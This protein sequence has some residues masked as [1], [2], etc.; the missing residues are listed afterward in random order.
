[1]K[2]KIRFPTI[3]LGSEPDQP[4]IEELTEFIRS[5]KSYEGDLITFKHLRSL[6]AQQDASITSPCTGG[7]FCLPRIQEAFP[8]PSEKL[9][10]DA[11]NLIADATMITQLAGS[12]YAALPAP[13]QVVGPSG[14]ADDEIFAD[15]CDQY[16]SLLRDMRDVHIRGHI[17]HAKEIQL[18][19]LELL[20]SKKTRFVI[21]EGDLTIQEELLEHQKELIISNKQVS[22]IAELIDQYEIRSLIIIEPDK[23]GF[24]L[25]LETMDRDQI[26]A[27]GYGNGN[28]QVYWR[29]ISSIAEASVNQ[30]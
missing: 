2:K 13:H 4:D 23:D 19:E 10:P 22:L 20:T 18:I 25:A 16:A 11:S 8:F 28:E 27:G 1:M 21:P 30:D 12:I 3:S 9:N 5:H 15:Y 26:S 17:L 7:L 6:K 24:H 14:T 29:M